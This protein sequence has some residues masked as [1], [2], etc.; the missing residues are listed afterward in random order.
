[1]AD[2]SYGYKCANNMAAGPKTLRKSPDPTQTQWVGSGHETMY[3]YADKIV[4]MAE[5]E[6]FVR[7]KLITHRWTF[8]KLSSYLKS[9]FPGTV[10][11][12]VRSLKRC[13]VHTRPEET[14]R[15]VRPEPDQ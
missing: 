4:K 5:L 9:C 7:D 8:T 15:L 13:G 10:G 2:Y 1:M 14:V 12:S 6:D 3:I 11:L